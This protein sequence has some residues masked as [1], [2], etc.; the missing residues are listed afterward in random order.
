M[1]TPRDTLDCGHSLA[2]LSAYLDTGQIADPAHMDSCPECQ[3]GLA[4][5][6]NLSALGKDLLRS[7]VADAGS[8]NDDWMQSILDNLQLELRPGRSIPLQSDHPHDTLWE[9]EGSISALIRSIVDALPGT[10]A[11]KCRLHGDVTT[12]G[13][14]ITVEV[15]IAVVYG[16]SMEERA[17]QLRQELAQTLAAH[18]ELAIEAINI[19]VTDVL[20]APATPT[21]PSTMEEQP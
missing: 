16:H 17:G 20:E 19:T 14:G 4:S 8:G 13:A 6:R 15:E 7:D 11:G 10:A 12:P 9:T 1:N 3:A 18:T 2:E 5:L 21:T